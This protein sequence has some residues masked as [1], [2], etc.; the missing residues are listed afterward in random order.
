MAHNTHRKRGAVTKPLPEG[1]VT[2]MTARS[3]INKKVA[4]VGDAV[5][6]YL[7]QHIGHTAIDTQRAEIAWKN[8]A[9]YL[10]SVLVSELNGH[11]ISSYMTNRKA[12][13]GTINRELGVL[14]AAIRWCYAQGYTDKLVLVPRLPSPPPRQ[15]WLS[16]Q[17]CDRLLAAARPYPHVWAFIAMA[18][19][20]GQRKEA[21]LGLTKDRVFWEEGFIDFNEDGPL[22]ERRKGR[23]VVPMSSE[24]RE[25]L[26]VL[27]SD[28][29]YVVNNN[30]RRV[31]DMRKAWKKVTKAAGLED[32]TP[33]TLRHTVATLLVR[34][35]V[36]LIEVS[37]L[38]GHKDSRITEKV[39]AKFSPDYLQ[40]ATGKLSIA[41]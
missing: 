32:V 27:Q 10:R 8:M 1:E 26:T 11:T 19:L 18:L 17:E 41:A 37:K 21:I 29:I 38:L 39:Y 7:S 5:H 20:T 25:L 33:H 35:G 31:R 30:G 40:N 36:P 3:T 16:K 34:A 2:L 28:S 14:S 15:R 23:A 22:C 9:I 13:A 24:M 4:T 6:K 12:S